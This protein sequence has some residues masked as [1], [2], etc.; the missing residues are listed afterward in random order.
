MMLGK[1]LKLEVRGASH[2][3]AIRFALDG[4]PKGYAVDAAALAAFMERRAPGRDRLS[5][6]RREADAVTFTAGVARGVTTGGTVRGEIRNTNARPAD[7]GV[8]RTVPRPGHADFGQWIETGIIP[9]GGGKNSGRLTAALCA[10]GGLCKQFLAARGVAV[11][12]TVESIHGEPAARRQ[13]HASEAARDA[14][15][16]VGGWVVCTATG[17]PAGLGGALADGLESPLAA[18]LF[19]IPGVKAVSFGD[20]LKAPEMLGSEFNDAFV[21]GTG[22]AVRTATNRQG[23]ILGGRTSGMPVTFHVALRPTPTVYKAQPSV[24]LVTRQPATLAMKGRHDPCIVR[25]A[26]PVVEAVAAFALADAILADEAERP[27]ICLTLTGATLAEDLAQYESQ[28]DFTDMV[29]LRID[30]LKPSERKKAKD[31]PK[32]L[33]PGLP[34]IFT[35]DIDHTVLSDGRRINPVHDFTG[36]VK[37]VDRKCRELSG[38]AGAIAKVA[39]QPK[40]MADVARL[41]RE[42]KDL[43]DVPHVTLAMGAQG[44]ATRVLA[45]RTRSLWASR[46]VG[47]LASVGHS[48]P[49]GLARGDALGRDGLAAQEDALARAPQRRVRDRG[50]GRGDGA[51]PGEDGARGA[52]LH[53]GDGDAGAGRHDSAQAGD[54]AASGSGRSAREEDRRGEH[55]LVRGRQVRRLQHG[56]RGLL[57]GPRRVRGRL[58]REARGRPRRRR[59]GAGREGRAQGA[60]RPLRGLPSPD[61]A[62]GLRPPRQRDAGRSDPGL[63][64]HGARARL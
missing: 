33:P 60:G 46:S 8:G 14:G 21:V 57:G 31:F 27:R 3:R 49:G 6:Q 52:R 2:A 23:G 55:R 9:T 58:A 45:G 51:V 63:R 48:S 19:A 42:T 38:K 54:P 5:T 28:R 1:I 7:Y 40:S 41:F 62:R 50:R 18:A 22:G 32:R 13:V 24:D 56:R 47:G 34:V 37:H 39:C 53:E 36:P 26:V 15:D 25:R 44:L 4:F 35:K 30:L 17:L 12:A 64:L 11:E 29:E 61:A 10:A 20:G 43:T 16:S 59:R